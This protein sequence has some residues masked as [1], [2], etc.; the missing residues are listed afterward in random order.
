VLLV[1]KCRL[2]MFSLSAFPIIAMQVLSFFI[3]II[4]FFF[5]P[6]LGPHELTFFPWQKT[7][8]VTVCGQEEHRRVEGHMHVLSHCFTCQFA[9]ASIGKEARATAVSTSPFE[10]GEIMNLMMK[11]NR[12]VNGHKT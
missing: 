10:G 12:G 4:I 8:K 5:L 2:F 1:V 11:R 3:I 9:H 7:S 6:F